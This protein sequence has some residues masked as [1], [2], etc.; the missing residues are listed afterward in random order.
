MCTVG[1]GVRLGGDQLIHSADAAKSAERF[2][3]RRGDDVEEV[4]LFHV[5][6]AAHAETLGGFGGVGGVDELVAAEP[7]PAT[8]RA[9]VRRLL[10]S[11]AVITQVSSSRTLRRWG[12]QARDCAALIRLQI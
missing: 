12:S 1:G 5:I 4:H 7:D 10:P 11:P 8:D 6:A 3:M 2:R 9:H